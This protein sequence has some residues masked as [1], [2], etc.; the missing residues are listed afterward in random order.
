[1]PL[2]VLGVLLLIVVGVVLLIGLLTLFIPA[3]GAVFWVVLAGVMAYFMKD[4]PLYHGEKSTVNLGTIFAVIAIGF[5]GM[6]VLNISPQNFINDL[7]P[8]AII[9]GA[10]ILQQAAG[11]EVPTS[12]SVIVVVLIGVALY[13]F[14]KMTK[15]RK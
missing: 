5:L 7:N 14:S 10:V 8:G 6:A 3:L 9:P 1:M 2:P 13:F 15:R 12:N 11:N 4:V